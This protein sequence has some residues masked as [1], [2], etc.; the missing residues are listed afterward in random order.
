[1]NMSAIENP[2]GHK[3]KMTIESPSTLRKMVE[4]PRELLEKNAPLHIREYRCSTTIH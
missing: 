2:L 3:Q 4:V 1:M